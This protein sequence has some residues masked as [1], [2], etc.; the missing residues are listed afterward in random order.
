M[1]PAVETCHC[2][3]RRSRRRARRAGRVRRSLWRRRNERPHVDFV[4]PRCVRLVRHPPAVRRELTIRL[5]ETE[6]SETPT[7]CARPPS[8][9]PTVGRSSAGRCSNMQQKAPVRGPTGGNHDLV[10]GDEALLSARTVRAD[11]VEVPCTRAERGEG[12]PRAVRRPDRIGVLTPDRRSTD[13]CA[14]R[15]G[16]RGP[17]RP[18]PSAS[19]PRGGRRGTRAAK[20]DCHR[21]RRRSPAPCPP[22]PPTSVAARCP[23]RCGTPPAPKAPPTTHLY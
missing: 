15:R 23:H 9:P 14:R 22:G 8:A 18:A 13:W 6:S 3:A 4:S 19:P 2:P 16:A 17:G 5:D 11:L 10:G 21:G 20:R 12:D 1:P 7:G